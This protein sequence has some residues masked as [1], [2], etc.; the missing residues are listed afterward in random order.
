MGAL[1]ELLG[2]LRGPSWRP[3]GP[4]WGPVGAFWQPLGAFWAPLGCFGAPLGALLELF[5]SPLGTFW[6]YFAPGTLFETFRGRFGVPLL[7][8]ML[9]FRG[10]FGVLGRPF[11]FFAFALA[12]NSI[13]DP[14]ML[15]IALDSP[16]SPQLPTDSPR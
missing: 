11:V 3:L 12:S 10:R 6:V 16:S 4:L 1:W 13:L 5:G 15:Q 2:A 8:L 9:T 7:T 14:R